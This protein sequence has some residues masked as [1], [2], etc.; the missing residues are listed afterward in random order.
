MVRLFMHPEYELILV[1]NKIVHNIDDEIAETHRF[2]VEIYSKKF[3]EL[4]SL[5]PNK[6]DYIRTVST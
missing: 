4:E 2:V 5:V 1:C 3:P 6:L